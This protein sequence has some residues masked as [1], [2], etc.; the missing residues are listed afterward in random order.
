[1]PAREVM[2]A[3]EGRIGHIQPFEPSKPRETSSPSV[4]L[5]TPE[6]V[7]TPADEMGRIDPLE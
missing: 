6:G 7:V 3:P 2:T 1:M 5:V 4:N